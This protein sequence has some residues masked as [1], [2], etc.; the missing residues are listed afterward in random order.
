MEDIFKNI[1][2][3]HPNKKRTILIV[4]YDMIAD[5]LNNKK[6]NLVINDLFTRGKKLNISLVFITQSY[7]AVPK[8]IRITS[9]HYFIMKILYKQEL[10][11]IAF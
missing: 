11:Q 10:H 4:S 6:L 7:F 9:T 8:N 1:E 2:E 5:I 3:Y